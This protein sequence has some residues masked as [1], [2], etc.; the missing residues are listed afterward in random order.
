[1]SK[2]QAEQMLKALDQ[3]EKDLQDQLGKERIQGERIKIEKDW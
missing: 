2:E 3:Q 1:M